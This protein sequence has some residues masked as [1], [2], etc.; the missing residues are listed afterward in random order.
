MIQ[1]RSDTGPSTGGVG[2]LFWEVQ[3]TAGFGVHQNFVYGLAC[4]AGCGG[5]HEFSHFS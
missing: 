2:G 4:L 3:T 5:A 1:V